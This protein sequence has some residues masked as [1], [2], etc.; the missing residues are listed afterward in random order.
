MASALDNALK[1][2]RKMTAMING[3]LNLSRLETGKMPMDRQHFDLGQLVR[4]AGEEA[5]DMDSGHR[6]IVQTEGEAVVNADREKIGQVIYNLLNNAA[7]Y[8]PPGT[9]IRVGCT[10]AAGNATV[11]VSDQGIGVSAEDLPRLFE[12][13]Y[14]VK[15]TETRHIA[16]FGIGLYL[17]AEIVKGNDGHIRAESTPGQGSTFYF[18]LPLVP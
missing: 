10:L 12:R 5:K 15:T 16:G 2:V 14:R 17:A 3:F 11:S 7:K 9:T 18:S 8:S 6:I 13:F 1:Q 4:E